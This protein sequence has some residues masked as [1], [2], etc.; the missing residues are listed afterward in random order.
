MP[1]PSRRAISEVG[2]FTSEEQ[3]ATA[4]LHFIH[5]RDSAYIC[6]LNERCQRLQYAGK[7]VIEVSA[8]LTKKRS[9]SPSIVS[10][11]QAG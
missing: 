5:I 2:P 11:L 9:I 3:G 6:I 10:R 1:G 7:A 4:I 8:E